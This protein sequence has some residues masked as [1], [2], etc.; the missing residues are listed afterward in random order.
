[1][2]ISTTSGAKIYIGTTAAIDWTNP[3]TARQSFEA[4]SYVEVGETENLG[5]YGDQSADVTFTSIGDARVRHLKG[6]RDAGSL[7]LVVGRD[8]L[9]PG[10]QA[11]KEAQKTKFEYNIKIVYEDAVDEDHSNSVHYFRAL[12]T[13]DRKNAG[14]ADDVTRVNYALGITSEILEIDSYPLDSVSPVNT[15]LPAISG[16]AQVGQELFAWPGIWTGATS[17]SY[18]WM[19]AGVDIPGATSNKYTPVSGDLGDNLSVKVNGINNAG[20]TPATSAE[21]EAVLAA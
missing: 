16:I 13:S 3:T 8:P 19:N 4:D 6:S 20:T 14:G 10:Q 18:Q 7:A 1:M 5:E 17:F 12:V 11:L 9:D 21:T 2:A 15:Q